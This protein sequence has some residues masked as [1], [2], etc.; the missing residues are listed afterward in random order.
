M[1]RVTG[2]D[3]SLT[4]GGET[5]SVINDGRRPRRGHGAHRISTDRQGLDVSRHAL[6]SRYLTRDNCSYQE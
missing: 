5:T 3:W 2:G 6:T 1:G 4:D